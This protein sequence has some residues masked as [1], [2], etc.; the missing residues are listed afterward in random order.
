M[1][2]VSDLPHRVKIVAQTTSK[3]VSGAPKEVD[4]V[5]IDSIAETPAWVFELSGSDQTKPD[6][7]VVLNSKVFFLILMRRRVRNL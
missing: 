3:G 2:S 1:I 4:A 7:K 5:S 6:E